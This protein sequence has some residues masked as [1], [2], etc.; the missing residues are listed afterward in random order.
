MNRVDSSTTKSVIRRTP[1][2]PATKLK[3]PQAESNAN[4]T[5][6]PHNQ[7]LQRPRANPS[8]GLDAPR[9]WTC[10]TAMAH[11]ERMYFHHFAEVPECARV[12]EKVFDTSV[13]LSS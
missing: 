2:W 8:V 4:K 3:T 10:I 5:D 6:R 12:G 1:P 7:R 9:R 13:Y 11:R